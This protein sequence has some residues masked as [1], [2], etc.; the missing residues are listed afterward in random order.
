MG[1]RVRDGVS[2][3]GRE[4]GSGWQVAARRRTGVSKPTRPSPSA[5]HPLPASRFPLPASRFPLP[6]SDYLGTFGLSLISFVVNGQ[7]SIDSL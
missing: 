1:E 2:W 5:V 6:A 7:Q 4:A 3:A